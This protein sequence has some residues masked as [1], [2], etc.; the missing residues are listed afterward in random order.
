[1]KKVFFFLIMAMA[2]GFLAQAQD[3]TRREKQGRENARHAK[4]KLKDE[5][6]LSKE[7]SKKSKRST[8]GIKARCRK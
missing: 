4:K 1:M 7:Q 8:T 3:S 6:D 5:L 2:F